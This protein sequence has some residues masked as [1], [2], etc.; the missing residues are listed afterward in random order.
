M[1]FLL[2]NSFLVNLLCLLN[3]KVCNQKQ[4]IMNTEVVKVLESWKSS[5]DHY[6]KL[7]DWR[8]SVNLSVLGSY[9]RTKDEHIKVM[10]LV[11]QIRDK[12]L[13]PMLDIPSMKELLNRFFDSLNL[14]HIEEDD[15]KSHYTVKEGQG[16]RFKGQTQRLFEERLH[17]KGEMLLRNFDIETESA[18][19]SRIVRRIVEKRMC[20]AYHRM[21]KGMCD[22]ASNKDRYWKRRA[23]SFQLYNIGQVD[24]IHGTSRGESTHWKKMYDPQTGKVVFKKKMAYPNEGA[25]LE[26]IKLWKIVHVEDTK[27]MAAYQCSHC[28]KWHIGH[29]TNNIQNTVISAQAAC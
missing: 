5:L 14:S 6:G 22:A 2:N 3:I 11:K 1:L 13:C 9:L 23:I 10:R 17:F 15:S 26:A 7:D 16:F 27:E 12:A 25:A 28:H 29:Y 19:D 21:N 4:E 8:L 18:H 24:D 20:Q